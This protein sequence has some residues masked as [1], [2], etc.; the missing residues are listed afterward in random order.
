MVKGKIKDPHFQK[1][2][3]T[4]SHL[5]KKVALSQYFKAGYFLF[6]QSFTNSGAIIDSVNVY[7][8]DLG[9][10][11]IFIALVNFTELFAE[12]YKETAIKMNCLCLGA[13]QT[14]MLEQAFPGYVAP[15]T[16]REMANYI[17]DFAQT[18]MKFFNGKILPVSI[19]TP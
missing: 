7:A 17:V 5:R 12:E 9:D 13:V 16:P 15:T 19:S 8:P 18:G 14:E 10:L 2:K 3:N 11:T 6:N 4:K 1:D